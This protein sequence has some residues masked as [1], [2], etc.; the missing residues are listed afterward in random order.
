MKRNP[1]NTKIK[2][3]S[4]LFM[5]LIIILTYVSYIKPVEMNKRMFLCTTNGERIIVNFNIAIKRYI[6]SPDIL[7]GT[8]NVEGK[9]YIS[10]YSSNMNMEQG[11]FMDRIKK[12]VKGERN[13]QYF[14]L[15][16]NNFEK[17]HQCMVQLKFS[18]E[19]NEVLLWL[20]QD[21]ESKVYYGP[22]ETKEEAQIIEIGD[23]L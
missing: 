8:I 15:P 19:Y 16:T 12:K 17:L 9:E 7:T 23:G 4:I 11:T 14:I 5:I 1:V 3:V 21:G 18:K 6:F 20:I 2:V 22:A 13:F 10:I